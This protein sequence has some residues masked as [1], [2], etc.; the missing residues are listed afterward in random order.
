[1][2]DHLDRDLA[3]LELAVERIGS[4]LVALERDENRQLIE[5]ATLEGETATRWLAASGALQDL[6]DGYASLLSLLERVGALRGAGNQVNVQSATQLERLLHGPAIERSRR[7][8]SLH[9]RGLLDASTKVDLVSADELVADMSRAFDLVTTTMSDVVRGWNELMPQV[10]ELRNRSA[11]AVRL[12]TELGGDWDAD[13]ARVHQRIEAFGNR[14]VCDPLAV[15][16]ADITTLD[17]ALTPIE[18][19]IN[20]VASLRAGFDQMIISA[21]RTASDLATAE[22]IAREATAALTSRIASPLVPVYE[23]S[24]PELAARLHRITAAAHEENWRTAARDLDAW[25][26]DANVELDRMRDATELAS[27][28]LRRRDELRGRLEAYNAKAAQLGLSED[29]EACRIYNSAMRALYDAPTD[30]E[31]AE[32][33]VQRYQRAITTSSP[34]RKARM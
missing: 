13:L 9:D 17:D 28:P 10:A 2:H 14:L 11:D 29:V 15:D 3:Q 19:E 4:N 33:L 7:P 23:C 12:S 27:L 20:H 22:Q 5:A 8:V 34:G 21:E 26:R 31:R 32:A 16:P 18:L 30:L 25:T 6:F 24:S 1:M